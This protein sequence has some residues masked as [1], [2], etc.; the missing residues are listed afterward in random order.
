MAWWK[1]PER[2]IGIVAPPP[3]TKPGD[4]PASVVPELGRRE[5]VLATAQED[6]DGHWLVLTTWRL[7]ERADDGRTVLERAWHEVDTGS[8][9]PD[10][11]TLTVLFVD[12]A[13]DRRWQLQLR[14]GPGSVPVV[15][16]DRTTASVVL[17][18][19]IDLGPRRTAR[20]TIRTVLA[21]RELLEQV[22]LGHGSRT[23]DAELAA[24]V[25]SARRELRD[26]VGLDPEP[27]QE[28]LG[29]R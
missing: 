12:G 11:W 26:Q 23:E 27:P 10:A 21:T 3:E 18:R 2:V 4:V 15:F 19:V 22:L 28:V 8:W 29:P 6:Q 17:T 9:D 7:L 25:F 24:R 20:V 16:R 13:E 14:T 5:Q 1:R